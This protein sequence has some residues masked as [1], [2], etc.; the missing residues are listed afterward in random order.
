MDNLLISFLSL[1]LGAIITYWIY[2]FI[3][4]KRSKNIIN[5]QSI[6]L[7]EKIKRVCKLITVE[8][9]FA[10]IYHYEDTKE[11][12]LKMISSKKKALL[13][14]NAKALIGFDLSKISIH[15]NT[16]T[17][18][19][20]LNS[21]PK[22][23]VL[24]IESDVQYYDKKDGLFNKFEAEDLTE[25]QKDAKAQIMAKIPESGLYLSA[26]ND[27]LA[28]ISLIEN[29]VQTIGWKLDYKAL[30]IPKSEEKKLD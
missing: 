17:K 7:L 30:E 27:A 29:I 1:V 18:T 20:V 16:K 24:S 4:K 2:T 23:E 10:E 19:I 11:R 12:L 13:I 25:L 14:I 6:V 8:G 9:D 26:T 15:A 5:T 28:T 22:P 3:D 21:F